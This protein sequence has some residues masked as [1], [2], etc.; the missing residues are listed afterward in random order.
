MRHRGLWIAAALV[1]LIAIAVLVIG[2][3]TLTHEGSKGHTETGRPAPPAA[4]R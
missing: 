4:A 1:G 3:V 2:T